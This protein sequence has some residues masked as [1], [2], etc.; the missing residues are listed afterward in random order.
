[1][2][3]AIDIG[4]TNIYMGVYQNSRWTICWRARSVAQKMPDE[5]AVLIHNFL[6]NADIGWKAITGVII[7]SVVPP[8][9]TAFAELVERY[10]NL[11]PIVVTSDIKTGVKIDIDQ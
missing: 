6:D 7:S 2:L 8:L 11:K 1:M 5:Y 4:N 9:T 10:T 3:L